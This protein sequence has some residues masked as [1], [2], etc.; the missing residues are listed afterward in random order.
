MMSA[1][2][3]QLFEH[4][5]AGRTR[6][7]RARIAGAL[8]GVFG[9]VAGAVG[10]A[11]QAAQVPTDGSA[12]V[13]DSYFPLDGNGGIDVLHYDVKNRYDFSSRVLKGRT[14]LTLR[15]TA[16]LRRFHLD[17][18]LTP[19]AVSVD[20]SPARFRKDGKHELVIRPALPLRAGTTVKVVVRHTGRPASLSYRGEKSFWASRHE[21]A[22][23][24]QPHAAPWWFAANDHPS[25]KATFSIA[26]SVPRGKE[27]V[28]NGRLVEKVRQG[29]RVL[30]R[31]EARDPMA[32]YLAF[33]AAGD[34]TLRSGTT[35][36]LP[37]TV[38]V[39]RHL[40]KREQRVS[41]RQ[42]TKS[43]SYVKWLEKHL[44]PYPFETTGGVALSFDTGFALENQTRPVYPGF[45]SPDGL[46]V[47]HEL[48]HQW[49]GDSVGLRRWRDIWINEGLATFMEWRREEAVGRDT[50]DETFRDVYR[51]TPASEGSW[52]VLPGNPGSKNLFHT[53][54]Y[55]RGA[56]TVQALRNRIG[57]QAFSTL[58]R[59]WVQ[60]YAGG[61]A[62][63]ADFEA[64]AE[65]IS[66]QD[67]A[68]FFTAWLRTAR[69]P[70][71]T[72][73]NGF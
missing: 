13:G 38:A 58:L 57:E 54:V 28:A 36:G 72:T 10:G 56:M 15:T 12:G 30:W 63:S 73:A 5:S 46:L 8:V 34:F 43:A 37:W 69:K 21:A 65:E 17:L 29:S 52:K 24:N 59:T 49:F 44:G 16:D 64:L 68:A 32:T 20:G 14:V 55:D 11:A 35:D 41:M 53:S 31:W 66:G 25:D 18:L 3:H 60:R 23:V 71:A 26:M 39:S 9:L 47:V 4:G 50:A 2:P 67:L 19:T 27:V 7:P 1:Q 48:A 22:A 61:T 70:S 40:S 6:R 51:W 45:S 33:F 62:T 42:L